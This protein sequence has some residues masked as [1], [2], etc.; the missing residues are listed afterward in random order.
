MAGPTPPVVRADARSEAV[1]SA[2]EPAAEAARPDPLG[3]RR[4]LDA[5]QSFG[6]ALYGS[7]DRAEARGGNLDLFA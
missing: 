6:V 3:R 4:V 7:A 2:P 5:G 1:A